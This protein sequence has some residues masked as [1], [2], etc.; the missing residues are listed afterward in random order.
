M[1]LVHS[2][3][4]RFIDYNERTAALRVIFHETG[5]YTFYAVPKSLFDAFL[6]APSKGHFFND[7]IR[8]RYPFS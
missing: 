1:P 6:H 4:I 7:H 2:S 3:A 8:D 5:S